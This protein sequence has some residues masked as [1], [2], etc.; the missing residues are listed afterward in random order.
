MISGVEVNSKTTEEFVAIRRWDTG[1]LVNSPKVHQKT[2]I[3]HPRFVK[4][5]HNFFTRRIFLSIFL[6]KGKVTGGDCCVVLP[7]RD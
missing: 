4:L 2:L 6:R 5:L 7:C 1:K 3:L